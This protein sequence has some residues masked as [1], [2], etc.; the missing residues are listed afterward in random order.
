MT[1]V[2]LVTVLVA[3]LCLG[4]TSLRVVLLQ[5]MA[6]PAGTGTPLLAPRPVREPR[7]APPE[8]P[9]EYIAVAPGLRPAGSASATLLWR[10]AEAHPAP[11]PRAE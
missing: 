9:I 5:R 10:R 6:V 8:R 3:L 4:L 11:M 1:R 7:P 2:F